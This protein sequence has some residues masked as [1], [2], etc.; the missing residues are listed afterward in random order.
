MN[1][2]LLFLLFSSIFLSPSTSSHDA[3]ILTASKTFVH[4]LY[5][6]ASN[7]VDDVVNGN[8]YCPSVAKCEWTQTPHVQQLKE[9]F[10]HGLSSTSS[11]AS[12]SEESHSLITVAV[13]HVHSL[14]EKLNSRYPLNCDWRTNLTMGCSEESGIRYGHLYNSTF[15]N[16]DGYSTYHPMASVQRIQKTAFFKEEDLRPNPHNFSYLIKAGSYVAKDCHTKGGDKANSNRDGVVFALRQAGFRIDGLSKCMKSQTPEGV[17]LPKTHD[18]VQNLL[19]KREA[20]ARF[21]FNMAFE[22]SIEDGY[23]T[24]K[25]FD[26]LMAG[27]VPIYLGD[28]AHLKKLLPHPKAAI[29]IADY[30]GDM[31]A[32]ANYLNY[33]TRNESAYEE[34]RAWRK[35]F[36]YAENIKDKP[37]LQQSW[38]CHVCQWA[39]STMNK[40]LAMPKNNNVTSSFQHGRL[41]SSISES[42]SSLHTHNITR[43]RRA[44]NT[45]MT[46]ISSSTPWSSQSQ[47]DHCVSLD[48]LRHICTNLAFFHGKPIRSTSSSDLYLITNQTIRSIPNADTFAS[49]KLDYNVLITAPDNE[50]AKCPRGPPL[51]PCTNC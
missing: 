31:K 43:R 2:L 36:S 10:H 6:A 37:M 18:N 9:K 21:M 45:T 3:T 17:Y 15:P 13:F 20:I 14:K 22:N 50:F 47:P 35:T 1:T 42:V 29:F 25:P 19:L 26:A 12:S 28:A 38:Y 23:V 27:T 34:H 24:E 30:N 33:L 32:L 16:F 49:L 48:K 11:N 46:S 4:V 51:S 39:V 8:Q 40:R 44:K 41:S 5:Y 7:W